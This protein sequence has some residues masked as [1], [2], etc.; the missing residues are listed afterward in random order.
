MPQQLPRLRIATL[1]AVLL[2]TAACSDSSNDPTGITGTIRG[3][4]TDLQTG[5]PLSGATVTFGT[6]SGI[7]G[8]NGTYQLDSVPQ[9]GLTLTVDKAGYWRYTGWV[10]FDAASGDLVRDVAMTPMQ[11]ETSSERPASKMG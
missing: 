3:T 6:T 4:V 11:A 1:L 5:A 9:G 8:A 7:T 2:L 10:V